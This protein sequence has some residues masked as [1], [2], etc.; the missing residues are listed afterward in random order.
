MSPMR[1]GETAMNLQQA[2]EKIEL[3]ARGRR[4]FAGLL[5]EIREEGGM[6]FLR[7]V[8]GVSGRAGEMMPDMDLARRWPE[9][10]EALYA[11]FVAALPYRPDLRRMPCGR[12]ERFM[13][14]ALG[15]R[16]LGK[17]MRV[18]LWRAFAMG[19][20]KI[21]RY[22]GGGAWSIPEVLV[23]HEATRSWLC[24]TRDPAWKDLRNSD[25][26]FF[27]EE[28]DPPLKTDFE[29]AAWAAIG[30]DSPAGL[31]MP[32]A[33]MGKALPL[34]F[35]RGV[36]RKRAAGIL[37]HLL[38]E[39][40]LAFRAMPPREILFYLCSNWNDDAAIPM[41]E[42]LEQLRP[43]TVAG[44]VDR[45]GHDALWYTLYQRDRAGR[46]TPAA[47][48]MSDPL[49]AALIGMGCDP[50]R[51]CFLGLAWRDVAEKS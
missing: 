45:F 41:V 19:G 34:A 15:D 8:A 21:P 22:G 32:L 26:Y 37:S 1:Y 3:C 36:L 40:E 51:E 27:M 49:D 39:P 17:P 25:P 29:K 47:R 7:Q 50:A 31:M 46:A 2:L 33:L 28:K 44:A 16:T 18:A 5:R 38:S 43:G 35:F 12:R 14:E 20:L 10:E 11:E 4:E 48:R 23:D 24:A 13:A 30:E 9:G 42:R 6:A